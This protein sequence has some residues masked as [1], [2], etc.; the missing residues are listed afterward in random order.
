MR[1]NVRE[2]QEKANRRIFASLN[3]GRAQN[4]SEFHVGAIDIF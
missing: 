2:R 1:K 4:K 3:I